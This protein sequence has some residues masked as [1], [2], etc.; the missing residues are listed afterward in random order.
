MG[1]QPLERDR[2]ARSVGLARLRTVDAR[3]PAH[4]QLLVDRVRAELHHPRW[5][6]PLHTPEASPRGCRT[7]KDPSRQL[8]PGA[9]GGLVAIE[10]GPEYLGDP[11]VIVD[12]HRVLD[13]ELV[14]PHP[15]PDPGI[16]ARPIV[17]LD[18]LELAA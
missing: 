13:E 3:H 6:H 16:P 5:R 18:A 14:P 1:Q 8:D 4:A 11:L 7:G 9:A 15:P 17:A 10:A 12:D 2:T